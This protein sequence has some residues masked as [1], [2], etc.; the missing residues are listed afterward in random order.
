MQVRY[1]GGRPIELKGPATGV[2]YRFSGLDRIQLV[3]P[4]DAVVI[5]RDKVFRI[6]GVIELTQGAAS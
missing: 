3:D 2:T 6:D 1:L 5:V 4:R